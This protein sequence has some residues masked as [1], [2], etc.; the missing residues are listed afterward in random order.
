MNQRGRSVTLV[1]SLPK[2][3]MGEWALWLCE[4]ASDWKSQEATRSLK[5]L[6]TQEE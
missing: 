6:K 1:Y 2:E 4:E 5:I 3:R